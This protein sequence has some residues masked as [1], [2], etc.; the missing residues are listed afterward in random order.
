MLLEQNYPIETLE[1]GLEETS[2]YDPP[3]L[4]YPAGA[5][6]C[7]IEIDPDTGEIDIKNYCVSDDFGIVMNP[8]WASLI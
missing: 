5:H 8:Y 6:I 7:E 4:T 3:N 2:F 1:P